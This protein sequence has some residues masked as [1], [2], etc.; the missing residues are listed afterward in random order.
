MARLM[1]QNK[2]VQTAEFCTELLQVARVD[3][4]ENLLERHFGARVLGLEDL[5]ISV[6][7][8]L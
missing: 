5:A 6:L 3:G 2:R 8:I 7:P 4:R 1:A